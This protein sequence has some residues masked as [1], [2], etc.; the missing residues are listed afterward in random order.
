MSRRLWLVLL[1]PPLMVAAAVPGLSGRLALPAGGTSPLPDRPIAA[2]G[3]ALPGG[4]GATANSAPAARPGA[5]WRTE[6][7]LGPGGAID[8]WT[9]RTGAPGIRPGIVDLPAASTVT[10]PV[11]GR[12][13]VAS[14]GSGGAARSTIRVVDVV[15]AC[16]TDIPVTGRIVR[17]AIADPG[18]DG[19]LAHLIE[20]GTRRD[21]GVWQIAPDGRIGRR[22]LEP[23]PEPL[24]EAAGM[25]VVWVTDLRLQ[26]ETRRLAVQSCHPDACVTRIVDLATGE[27]DILAGEGQGPIIGISG[28]N[29]V[30]W[31]A[32]HG[33][34]CPVLAWER[35]GGSPR[36]L[37]AEAS[38]AALTGDARRL[39]AIRSGTSGARE[40]AAIDVRTGL[41]RLLGVPGKDAW[42]LAGG[43]GAIAGLEVTGEAAAIGVSGRVPVPLDL[44]DP[45]ATVTPPDQEV[46]P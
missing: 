36:T 13:V 11:G 30:T 26:A 17:R 32:C 5:W 31:A 45:S 24:R 3:P 38:G 27:V 25:D 8:G 21:L 20:P 1:G 28:T 15:R 10:G 2:C 16:S 6:P 44:D 22:V 37:A 18:G 35:G 4:T 9:L 34:P 40:L 29:L 42:P 23:L 19:V 7:N 46:Q 43:A 41:S 14:E 39:V 12:V 33:L